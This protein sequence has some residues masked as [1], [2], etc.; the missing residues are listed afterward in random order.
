MEC[1]IDDCFAC[2]FPD[3]ILDENDKIK[4]IGL[5]KVGVPKKANKITRDM[6]KY[7]RDYY[8]LNQEYLKAVAKEHAAVK[9]KERIISQQS[10]CFYCKKVNKK[11][12]E[13]IKYHKYYFCGPECLGNYLYQRAEDKQEAIKM[14]FDERKI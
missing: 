13:V 4:P 12:H 5:K 6:Q 11:P 2:P 14:W 7:N 10:T 3:C 8:I 1:G 9:R